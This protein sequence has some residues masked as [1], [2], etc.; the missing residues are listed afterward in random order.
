ML[1]RD[2]AGKKG[3]MIFPS[4]TSF[5]TFLGPKREPGPSAVLEKG[6]GNWHM[7]DHIH[8]PNWIEAIRKRD[9][10]VLTA[11]IEEGHLSTTAPILG[12]ISHLTGRTLKFDPKTERFVNDDEADRLLSKEY[13]KPYVVPDQV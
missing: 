5:H 4:Y 10:N 7:V 2:P 3:Y 9:R 11:D 6:E 8:H 1:R 13:R 12:S